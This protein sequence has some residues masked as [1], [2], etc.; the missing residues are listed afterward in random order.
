MEIMKI[1]PRG[2]ACTVIFT[3][4]HYYFMSDFCGL[5]AIA[6]R[7]NVRE[8]IGSGKQDF[9]LI[10]GNEHLSGGSL[11]GVVAAEIARAFIRKQENKYVSTKVTFV[12]EQWQD[13][14]KK[15]LSVQA[16]DR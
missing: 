9:T 1:N 5:I 14:D 12:S 4:S 10:Y 7:V 6:E 15:Y 3:G 8:N 11:G 2:Y 13:L 16:L